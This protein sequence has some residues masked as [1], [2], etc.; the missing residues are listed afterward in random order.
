M[1]FIKNTMIKITIDKLSTQLPLKKIKGTVQQRL[2]KSVAMNDKFY[3]NIK[4]DFEKRDVL[5]S[6]YIRK[7]KKTIG[8]P[9][10]VSISERTYYNNPVAGGETTMFINGEDL[11]QYGYDI[12]LPL[13]PVT[14]RISRNNTRAFMHENMHVL[15]RIFN[16]KY[17]ARHISL[18]NKGYDVNSLSKFYFDKIY[19]KQEL[20][21]QDLDTFLKNKKA[22]EKIDTLQHWR[23]QLMLEKHA[24][25]Y[26][27]NNIQ[28][29]IKLIL[30]NNGTLELNNTIQR[31][32]FDEKIKMIE[33]KL[34]QI[35]GLEREMNKI[36]VI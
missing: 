28:K 15:D 9:I 36:L 11:R 30:G 33:E 24:H 8:A 4:D 21:V 27:E 14:E 32:H 26:I 5:P 6:V 34:A 1:S 3:E 31:Y 12:T 20:K 22:Q 29:F 13:D 7:L 35:I 19:S 17:N 2:D 18:V 23:Y 10:N 25:E 16:P